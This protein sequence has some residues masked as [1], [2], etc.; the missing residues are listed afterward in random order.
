MDKNLPIYRLVL[1]ESDD[2]LVT[3]SLVA[4]P[5]IEAAFVAFSKEHPLELKFSS[6]DKV[7][8]NVTGPFLVPNKIIY[9]RNAS[10]GE[11]LVVFTDEDIERAAV[12][13]GKKGAFANLSTDHNGILLGKG[14]YPIEFWRTTEDNERGLGQPKGTLM[15]TDH[16]EDDTTWTRVESGELT[17]F[18]IEGLFRYVPLSFSAHQQKTTPPVLTDR[19]I[20]QRM[21]FNEFM[22]DAFGR[23]FSSKDKKDASVTTPVNDGKENK[24]ATPPLKADEKQPEPVAM[25][26][27]PSESD[28]R[29]EALEQA[30][31]SVTK[32]LDEV[33]ASG[34][35][36]MSKI[37][38]LKGELAST[39]ETL[40]STKEELTK[41]AAQPAGDVI[42]P[43]KK[44]ATPN[45]YAN[46]AGMK[47]LLNHI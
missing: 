28:K 13:M 8:R 33:L 7:K 29:I 32:K 6:T 26:A 23:W 25:N 14:A 42:N 3:T 40:A 24:D 15:R 34:P 21:T 35:V 20:N 12:V 44:K 1:D 37:D 30:L 39:K 43:A 47:R 41:L 9:Q 17:G 38:E 10:K 36:A 2:N 4:D 5:A 45:E 19:S 11:H 31:M 22:E 16:I 46:H 18:S 27:T